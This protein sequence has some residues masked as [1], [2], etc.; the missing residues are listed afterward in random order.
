M[1][2]AKAHGAQPADLEPQTE[3]SAAGPPSPPDR[4]IREAAETADPQAEELD[5]LYRQA[6]AAMDVVEMG[7]ET[8][9]GEIDQVGT[10]SPVQPDVSQH[11]E[12]DAGEAAADHLETAFVPQTRDHHRPDVAPQQVLEAALFVGGTELTLKRLCSLLNDEFPPDAVEIMID[13]LSRRYEQEARP[14]EILFGKGGYRMS[15]RSEFSAVRNRVFGLGPREI[16]LSQEALEVLSLVAYRQPITAEQLAALR[17]GEVSKVLRQLL[18]RELIQLERVDGDRNQVRYR[19]TTRFLQAFGV[20]S[21][22]DL[23]QSEDLAFK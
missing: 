18:R 1:S 5:A 3:P 12:R 22:D 2:A 23:P 17:G 7:C 9:A 15:L 20:N 19:T 14:Y 4:A 6:L 11:G 16:K 13:E 10:V 21:L 8:A